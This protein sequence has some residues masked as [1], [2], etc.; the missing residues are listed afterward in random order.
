MV[1]GYSRPAGS[2][3][4]C[5]IS[6]IQAETGERTAI[7]NNRRMKKY[8]Y[9][10]AFL[11]ILSLVMGAAPGSVSTV[12][13]QSNEDWTDPLNLSNSGSS[14]SPS[15]VVDS[16]GTIHAFWLDEFNGYQY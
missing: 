12:R 2:I 7:A 16:K 6:G 15:V 11:F 5:R 13:A 3:C 8:K 4:Q 10:I 1:V 9:L 14:V